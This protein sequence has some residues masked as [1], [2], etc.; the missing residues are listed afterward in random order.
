MSI[1]KTI[2]IVVTGSALALPALAENVFSQVH[3][4]FSE[5]PGWEG[6][7]NRVV[8]ENPPTKTQEFGYSPTTR[9]TSTPGEIG[10]TMWSSRTPAW[11]GMPIG[12]PLSYKDS[13][14]FSGRMALINL[15][16]NGYIGFFNSTRQEWRPWSALGL[17]VSTDRRGAAMT[18]KD[19]PGGRFFV[20]YMTATWKA[21]F[22]VLDAFIPADASVH[23]FSVKYDPEA[24]PDMR[25]P[26]AHLQEI[27]R[28]GAKMKE[29]DIFSA[30]QKQEPAL[31]RESLRAMLDKVRDQGLLEYD[32][33]HGDNFW[34]PKRNVEKVQGR[35]TFQLDQDPPQ[36]YFLDAGIRDE[37]TVMDRFG[38]WNFQI[39]EGRSVEFY[40]SD[41]VINGQKID[42]SRDPNWQGMNNRISFVE[43]D[44]HPG[45]NYGYSQ[46]NWAGERIGEIGG[47][48]WRNEPV[49][50]YHGFYAD[51]V[52]ELT[53]DD[54]IS[55][56][57]S[58]TFVNGGTDASMVFGYFN[59]ADQMQPPA[60]DNTKTKAQVM[61]FQIADSTS[62]GY[63]FMP[64]LRGV[65]GQASKRGPQFVP[66]RVRRKF[67]FDYD[68]AANDGQ[69]RITAKLDDQVVTIDARKGEVLR[70]A[71]AR[72]DRFGL[73]NVRSGGKYVEVYFDDLTYTVKRPPDFKPPSHK[74]KPVKVPYPPGGR[75]Y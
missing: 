37:P 59:R 56:S 15:K 35:L 3:Q 52:G 14:S 25:W 27:F 60:V 75:M 41:L 24:R 39:P 69:G 51:D 31:T 66:D 71:G 40:V 57:G 50:P 67:S 45:Q 43:R 7:N 64:V 55:F 34:E 54:P 63:S 68:P 53:L 72:F 58:I 6:V 29:Q 9:S 42:L 12:K 22:M 21:S 17:R 19:V 47:L 61:G 65:S 5:D 23:T 44:F 73:L 20:D 70:H 30:I 46:T 18:A 74:D 10:G 2:L 16:G 13:F 11:Y 49:D 38:L 1:I 62:I 33:H 28:R 48:F 4:D 36:H 26:N 8:A 32:P